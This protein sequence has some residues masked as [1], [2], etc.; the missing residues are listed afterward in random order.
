MSEPRTLLVKFAEAGDGY[1]TWR[2]VSSQGPSKSVGV[3][4]IDAAV[5]SAARTTLANATPDPLPGETTSEGVDRALLD[6]PFARPDTTAA[7]ARELGSAL[8]PIELTD[9]LKGEPT[10]P[11]VRLQPSPSL[12]RV[13]WEMLHVGAADGVAFD[14]FADIV[15]SAP[16]T[17]AAGDEANSPWTGPVV[18]VIDPRI[19]GQSASSALGSV[20]GR[21]SEVSPLAAL[22]D[23]SPAIRPPAASYSDLAR[24]TDVDRNWLRNNMIDAGRLLYVGHVSAASG[25]DDESVSAALH[26]CCTDEHG[27][28]RPLT[29]YDVLTSGYRLP[30][31]T[32]LIG[33]NSGGD[34]EH[35]DGMGLSM[36]ALA[37]GAQL[38]TATRWAVPTNHALARAG[39]LGGRNPLEDLILAVDSAHDCTD[40]VR[41]LGRWQREQ[42]ERWYANGDLAD[43]PLLW[44]ALTTTER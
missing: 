41:S 32:A 31:R 35:P 5:L 21:P 34:L 29:A 28:H 16:A 19:P 42:R 17:V 10:R 27:T 40:P 20:L 23:R 37:T 24:R 2:W 18:A 26:L 9:T 36:A 6:G 11:M 13:P 25:P 4:H 22:L 3:A 15:G 1:L 44:A 38:V 7:L 30:P 14:E 43:A 8:I 12:T 33:C 39:D